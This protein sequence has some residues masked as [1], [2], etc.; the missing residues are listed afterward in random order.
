M[1]RK[2]K[3]YTINLNFVQRNIGY[4]LVI[5]FPSSALT[6]CSEEQ[7]HCLHPALCDSNQASLT[8]WQLACIW[9]PSQCSG[10]RLIYITELTDHFP[11]ERLQSG[12]KDKGFT[13][14]RSKEI[15]VKRVNDQT[16][17]LKN[18]IFFH[19]EHRVSGIKRDFCSY[20]YFTCY[21]LF[22]TEI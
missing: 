8:R 4:S 5:L 10:Q 19:K 17:P 9:L 16:Y 1:K 20:F 7:Q 18:F 12:G 14:E 2:Y 15:T 22:K 13:L 3:T 11:Q 21:L 6:R